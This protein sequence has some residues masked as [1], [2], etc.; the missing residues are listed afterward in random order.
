RLNTPGAGP[1]TIDVLG[2][3]KEEVL[4]LSQSGFTEEEWA[5]L[6]RV[7]VTGGSNSADQPGVLGRYAIANGVVRFTPQFPFDPG[8]RYEA[9][10]DPARIPS[11]RASGL[12]SRTKRLEASIAVPAPERHPTTRV[13]EVFPSGEEV[14]ENLLKLYIQFSAPMG[15]AGG[16]AYV[17]LLDEN[18]R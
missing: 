2:L 15:L 14:P 16:T 10:F 12:T 9:S 11:K 5:T 7:T 4:Q 8:Q 18:G 13:V 1:Q 6:F 17:H 3:S